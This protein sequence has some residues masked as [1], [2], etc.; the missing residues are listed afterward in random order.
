MARTVK[1][2]EAYLAAL[3]RHFEHTDG[4][5]VV[6]GSGADAPP[7]YVRPEDPVVFSVEIGPAPKGDAAHES[8]FFRRLLELNANDLL[9]CAYGL[10]GEA[11]VLSAALELEN[12]DLNEVEAVFSDM[13]L[14]LAQHMGE[15]VK[16]SGTKGLG[17]EHGSVRAP[18]AAHQGEPE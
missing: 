3:G 10:R 13:D 18:R 1:D 9:Y 16:L 17:N 8:A 12:L 4:L 7:I 2:L 11:V 6:D 14:A 5:L 15:L